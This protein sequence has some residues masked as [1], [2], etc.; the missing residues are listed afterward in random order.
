[1]IFGHCF[2][3]WFLFND[4]VV[5]VNYSD[6]IS[7]LFKTLSPFIAIISVI[8]G[9]SFYF[10]ISRKKPSLKKVVTKSLLLIAL[11]FALNLLI[12]GTE[13]MF[14]WDALAFYGLSFIVAFT[15]INHSVKLFYF[16]G[17]IT[18]F[19]GSFL[20]DLLGKFS[21]NY[22]YMIILGDKTGFNYW[23]FFPWFSLFVA[24]YLLSDIHMKKRNKY[25]LPI[26]ISLF[27]LSL[28]TKNFFFNYD[29]NNI[30]G[31]Q[32]FIINPI[33]VLGMV[34]LAIILLE[35]IEKINSK[36][37]NLFKN[38]LKVYSYS[39]LPV[40]LYH[41]IIGNYLL[42]IINKNHYSLLVIYLI[43]MLVSSY[44]IGKKYISLKNSNY[45]KI[46]SK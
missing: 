17:V 40:Y 39:I 34:G 14:S 41:L 18:L 22:I 2:L 36:K 42:S 43:F 44:F 19:G 35:T 1:M 4:E 38:L 32:I 9:C 33:R 3:G 16:A 11:C 12:W 25:L 28:I 15:L 10:W 45:L 27:L 23:P 7:I 20:R 5:N 6:Y 37:D 31:P 46:S 29:S 26:G 24:G 8:V 30:W 13:D 21:E